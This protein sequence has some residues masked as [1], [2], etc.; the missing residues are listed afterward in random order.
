MLAH[1]NDKL[2]AKNEALVEEVVELK[3][4]ASQLDT[5]NTYA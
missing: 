2:K 1:H 4:K 5:K 3:V